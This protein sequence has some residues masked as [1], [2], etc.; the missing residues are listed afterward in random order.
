MD[1]DYIRLNA[2]LPL[3]P[4]LE[5]AVPLLSTMRIICM[6]STITSSF[7]LLPRYKLVYC[8]NSGYAYCMASCSLPT[9]WCRA[10]PMLGDKAAVVPRLQLDG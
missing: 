9:E 2:V 10:M 6:G 3:R 1:A 4:D 7:E 8:L 5:L